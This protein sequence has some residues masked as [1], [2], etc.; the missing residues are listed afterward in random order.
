MLVA[1]ILSFPMLQE[2]SNK[3]KNENTKYFKKRAKSFYK[4]L[5]QT[6]EANKQERVTSSKIESDHFVE[7]THII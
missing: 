5:V 2:L 7:K 3:L 6:T 4:P 1:N